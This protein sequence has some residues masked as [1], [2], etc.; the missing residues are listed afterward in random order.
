VHRVLE[1]DQVGAVVRPTKRNWTQ[2]K[3]GFDVSRARMRWATKLCFS[4]YEG[5][6]MTIPFLRETLKKRTF[7]L[8]KASMAAEL[9]GLTRIGGRHRLSLLFMLRNRR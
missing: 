8:L 5:V 2:A 9:A 3:S 7:L 6:D 1:P 4:G